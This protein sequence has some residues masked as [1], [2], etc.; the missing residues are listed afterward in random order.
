MKKSPK[1]TENIT[2]RYQFAT[3]SNNFRRSTLTDH[4]VS[5]AHKEALGKKNA[6]I[7]PETTPA[8]QGLLA[9]QEHTRKHRFKISK[10]TRPR[11]T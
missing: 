3:G 8:A 5:S 6:E 1:C 7:K 9:L 10:R 11:L 2:N 4:E